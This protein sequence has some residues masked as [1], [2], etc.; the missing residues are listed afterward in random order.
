MQHSYY[1][2]DAE[3]KHLITIFLSTYVFK[4]LIQD[5]ELNI[6]NFTSNSI[7]ADSLKFFGLQNK[8]C[9]NVC[10]ILHGINHKILDSYHEN[11]I[12][13]TEGNFGFCNL[14]FINHIPNLPKNGVTSRELLH[15]DNPIVNMQFNS[16]LEESDFDLNMLEKKLTHEIA[17]LYP[18][19][20]EKRIIIGYI[21]Y[22]D[23]LEDFT[24]RKSFA[25]E[26][27]FLNKIGLLADD[28]E[29][30]F[31]ILYSPH[32]M[33]DLNQLKEEEIFKENRF[34]F[35]NSTMKMN[36][37]S[38]LSFA[39]VSG[40]LFEA[41]NYGSCIYSPMTEDQDYFFYEIHNLFISPETY[42]EVD[43]DSSI[44]QWLKK[45]EPLDLNS[46]RELIK[47]NLL[48]FNNWI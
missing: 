19:P 1:D 35:S 31:D 38:D 34:K 12:K 23:V 47:Q 3:L 25:I 2:E 27:Y 48:Q 6:F 46:R 40:A 37:F 42:S 8:A 24:S 33:V 20:N 39:L 5:L 44:K 17:K 7:I 36:F 9:S 15:N 4:N 29:D 45:K 13:L 41:R 43:I 16:L 11:L 26:K 18:D 30:S 10:E 14:R 21:G 28:L 22:T 32:P